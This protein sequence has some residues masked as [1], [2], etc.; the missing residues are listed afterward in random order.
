MRRPDG[1]I[2]VREGDMQIVINESLSQSPLLG[3]QSIRNMFV[4]RRHFNQ[5]PPAPTH[6]DFGSL[7]LAE[8]NR[9]NL[10]VA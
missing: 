7:A 4:K 1:I 5:E 8:M 9:Q 2:P 6:K 3:K 10:I